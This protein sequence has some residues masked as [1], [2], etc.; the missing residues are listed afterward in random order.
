MKIICVGQNKTGTLTLTH[1]FKELKYKVSGDPY[2]VVIKKPKGYIETMQIDN[3]FI[4][5]NNF[6]NNIS[7]LYDNL[8]MF[9]FFHDMPYLFNYKLI[10]EQYPDSKFILTTRDEN[11]WFKS[12][13]EYTKRPNMFNKNL[14]NIMYGE[15]VILEEHKPKVIDLYRKYNADVITYFKDKPDKLLIINLCE[16]NKDERLILDQIG[17]FIGKEIPSDFIFP[18]INKGTY[19]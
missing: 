10:N 17:S 4:D 7:Y 6:F 13:L 3:A 18:Y 14:L 5:L 8:N 9:D 1:I 16:K 11:D 15:Y 12:L 2:N 19:K